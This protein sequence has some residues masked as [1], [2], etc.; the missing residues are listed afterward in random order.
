MEDRP[1]LKF[2]PDRWIAE[3]RFD[4]ELAGLAS[5]AGVGRETENAK[6]ESQP[7]RIAKVAKPD[8]HHW[9]ARLAAL[10]IDQPLGGIDLDRWRMLIADCLWLADT[11]GDSAAALDWSASDLFGIDAQPGRG[12][13]AD[14]LDGA[15]H[16]TFTNRIA[17]WRS[18]QCDGWLWRRTLQPRLAIWE[19]H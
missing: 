10:T 5:L 12:G 14:R 13:L 1:M 9:R 18:S 6:S 8:P 15:R 2:D 11:H 4:Q 7:A 3:R 19:L 17:H 16:V